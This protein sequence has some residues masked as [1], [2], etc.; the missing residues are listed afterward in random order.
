MMKA[1]PD[2]FSADKEEPITYRS[3]FDTFH[4]I[5]PKLHKEENIYYMES[6]IGLEDNIWDIFKLDKQQ[7]S[8]FEVHQQ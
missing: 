4:T 6:S 1:F 5:E 8:L 3:D 2:L 7:V